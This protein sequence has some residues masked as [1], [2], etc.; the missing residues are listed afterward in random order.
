M[1]TGDR[2]LRL[3]AEP[4]FIAQVLQLGLKRIDGDSFACLGGLPERV[5][6]VEQLSH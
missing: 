5:I 2:L 4:V 6:Y 3:N 1:S